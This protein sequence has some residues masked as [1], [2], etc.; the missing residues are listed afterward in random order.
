MLSKSDHT[1]SS[2]KHLKNTYDVLK[3]PKE[4]LC[5]LSLTTFRAVKNNSI[6]QVMFAVT[7]DTSSKSKRLCIK[8][9]A[10]VCRGSSGAYMCSLGVS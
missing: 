9:S 4:H 8:S 10:C 3:T 5:C 1:C 7:L 6:T 2:K